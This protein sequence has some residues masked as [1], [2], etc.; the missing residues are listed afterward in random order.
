MQLATATVLPMVLKSAIELNLL[1]LIKKAGPA[2][3]VSSADLAA[4]I[5]TTNPAARD[6]LD[7]ILRLLATHSVLNCRLD[8]LPDGGVE[9]LY[10]LAPVCE[11]L[12]KNEDGVSVAPL[13]LL[14]QDKVFTESWYQLKDAIRDGEIPFK[15]AH[16]STLFEYMAK[17]EMFN[18]LFNQAMS[19]SSTILMKEILETY[20]GFEGLK[21]MVDVGG[22][23]GAT[24]NTIISKYPSIKGINFDLSHVI[25]DAPSYPGVEHV[26]GDMFVSLPKADAI[27]MRWICHVWTDEQCLKLLKNC[28]E[29]LPENGK[30]ILAEYVLPD[31]PD[32]GVPTKNAVNVDL[33]VLSQTPG[34][35]ER[36]EKEFHALAKGAGF[37]E[38]HKVCCAYDY[39]V[40]EFCK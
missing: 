23:N 39:W 30:V 25:R 28:Y 19:N 5:P 8:S 22:G 6:I 37:K 2:A 38:F 13:L 16:G 12:T 31:G 36:T 29:A 35:K 15:K 24:L 9:R 11:F 33:H 14:L 26:V 21:S 32:N 40:M 20:D 10:S 3:Y 17:D 7:R 27:F 4:Q 34:G 18:K 1:E